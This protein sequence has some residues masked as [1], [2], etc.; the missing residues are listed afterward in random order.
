MYT[1]IYLKYHV[2]N[3]VSKGSFEIFKIFSDKIYATSSAISVEKD[4]KYFTNR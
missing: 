3:K 4:A 1:H 2:T